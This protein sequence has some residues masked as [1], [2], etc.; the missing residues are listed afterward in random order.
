MRPIREFAAGLLVTELHYPFGL[1]CRSKTRKWIRRVAASRYKDERTFGR[2]SGAPCL[3]KARPVKAHH[4]TVL[5]VDD[6][7]R[8]RALD[9]DD[10]GDALPV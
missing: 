9:G 1:H 5:L 2:G 6:G 8:V 7:A 3:I 10:Y 4:G